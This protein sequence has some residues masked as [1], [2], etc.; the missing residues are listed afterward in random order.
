[1]LMGFSC[2]GG[3]TSTNE[4]GFA[5]RTIEEASTGTFG[6]AIQAYAPGITV[7][8]T[9]HGDLTGAYGMVTIFQLTTNSEGYHF[10]SGARV[11]ALWNLSELNGPCGGQTVY[12]TIVY[13]GYTVP[14]VCSNVRHQFSATPTPVDGAA[15]PLVTLT[16]EGLSTSFGQ[17]EAWLIDETGALAGRIEISNVSSDGTTAAIQLPTLWTGFY[18][19]HLRNKL[20]DGSLETIGVAE[21]EVFGN[22]PPPPP[23]PPECNPGDPNMD[24]MVCDY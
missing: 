21:M 7:Y 12:G 14:L 13:P 24:Q 20:G 18:T 17:P 19:V 16:G 6:F 22:D 15:P 1:M 8:G 4:N 3:Q 10:I 11:P 2:F 9:R 23:P 5:V